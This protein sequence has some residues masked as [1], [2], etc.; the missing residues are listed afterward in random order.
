[1]TSLS[2]TSAGPAGLTPGCPR[3]VRWGPPR[4]PPQPIA[5]GV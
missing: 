4:Y 5:R 3:P 1:M 2:E